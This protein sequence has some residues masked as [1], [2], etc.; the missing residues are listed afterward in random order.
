MNNVERL[1]A[2][3]GLNQTQLAEMVGVKQPHISRIERGDEGPPLKL[4]RAI[5][6]ALGVSL[7]DLFAD[8]RSAAER[9]LLDA[10]SLLPPARQMGWLEM[11][12]L[13]QA[14]ARAAA[15]AAAQSHHP[16]SSE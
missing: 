4:F 7:A 16:A 9:D 8:E 6:E 2:L 13:T 3:R 11:A 15:E 10:F 5:A 1:R 12:R 14:E